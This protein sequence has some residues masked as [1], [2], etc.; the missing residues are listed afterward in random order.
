MQT[1]PPTP[2]IPRQPPTTY[3]NAD[4]W[5]DSVVQAYNRKR[6]AHLPPLVLLVEDDDAYR[7]VLGEK[8]VNDGFHVASTENGAHAL[9]FLRTSIKEQTDAYLPDLIV[10]DI[11]MPNLNGFELLDTVREISPLLPTILLTGFGTRELEERA[12]RLGCD[13]FLRKPLTYSDLADHMRRLL[14]A[15]ALETGQKTD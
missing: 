2:A 8:M 10:S 4:R 9:H 14:L 12:L 1:T 7:D 13:Q 6:N 5:A 11:R 3:R 15:S